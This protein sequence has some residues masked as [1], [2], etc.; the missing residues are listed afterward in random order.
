MKENE[1]PIEHK[2][3]PNPCN[4]YISWLRTLVELKDHKDWFGYSE[5]YKEDEGNAWKR[6]RKL[7]TGKK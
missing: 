1:I 4:D 3:E 2:L 7:L 6:A 5:R